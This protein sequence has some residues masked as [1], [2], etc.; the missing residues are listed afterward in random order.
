M[1]A[2]KGEIH[3]KEFDLY[4]QADEYRL[5]ENRKVVRKLIRKHDSSAKSDKRPI[6][7]LRQK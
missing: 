1:E 7:I 3:T 6:D 4:T 2:L 5:D